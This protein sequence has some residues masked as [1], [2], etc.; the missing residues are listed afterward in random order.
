MLTL[1]SSHKGVVFAYTSVL[2]TLIFVHDQI[3]VNGPPEIFSV[4]SG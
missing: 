2:R 4:V 3:K 1:I